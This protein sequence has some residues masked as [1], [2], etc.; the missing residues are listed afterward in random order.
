MLFN[1]LRFLISFVLLSFPR[2]AVGDTTLPTGGVIC[3]RG[4]FP[5]VYISGGV[6]EII[7]PPLLDSSTAA[8][9]KAVTVSE[10]CI[11]QNEISAGIFQACVQDGYCSPLRGSQGNPDYP[12]H[13]ITYDE[14]NQFLLWLQKSKNIEYRLPTEAEWQFAALG[15][16][17]D[18]FPWRVVGRL[19]NVNIFSGE[20]RT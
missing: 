9:R 15:G 19:P 2:F 11:S 10:F 18:R 20:N 13:S 12:V 16:R 4:A 14:V 1:S 17:E 3:E 7:S 8:R 5:E 6:T